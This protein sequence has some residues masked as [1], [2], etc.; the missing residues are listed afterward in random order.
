MTCCSSRVAIY[1]GHAVLLDRRR[2]FHEVAL[3]VNC[4]FGVGCDVADRI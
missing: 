4:C 3:T 2:M 1:G